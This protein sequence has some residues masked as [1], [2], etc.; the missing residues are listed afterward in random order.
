M[1]LTL[2]LFCTLK[3]LKKTV[4]HGLLDGN[5]DYLS[6][7]FDELYLNPQKGTLMFRVMA[8]SLYWSR[9]RPGL[10]QMFRVMAISLVYGLHCYCLFSCGVVH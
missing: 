7:L 9:F 5:K 3:K 4:M 6:G 2:T 8:I 10:S 1:Y